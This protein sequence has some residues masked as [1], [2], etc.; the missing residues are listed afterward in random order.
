M[1]SPV[2]TTLTL[3]FNSPEEMGLRFHIS[4]FAAE[5]FL[6]CSGIPTNTQSVH[7]EQTHHLCLSH[8]SRVIDGKG[9]CSE[10]IIE[11]EIILKI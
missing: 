8:S 7:Q 2:F 3:A 10:D 9:L 1:N 4:I 11:L 6:H 5:T